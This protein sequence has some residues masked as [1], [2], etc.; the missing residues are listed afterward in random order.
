MTELLLRTRLHE[1]MIELKLTQAEKVV[2]EV[3]REAT[4]RQIS[5]TDVMTQL[6]EEELRF[7]R[8]RGSTMRIQLAHFPYK[9]TIEQFDFGFQPT[10]DQRKVEELATMS[11]IEEASNVVFLGPPGVG[12]THLSVAL[13]IRAC[14]SGYSTYF[15]SGHELGRQLLASL[16]DETTGKKLI[17]LQKYDLLIIDEMGYLPFEPRQATL[18]FQLVAKRYEK[19]SIIL[20]SNKGF[21][22]WAE[23]FGGDAAVAAAILDRLLHHCSVINV[24]GPSYRLKDRRDALGLQETPQST[25]Q[26]YRPTP[27]KGGGAG[28]AV[29]STT[30]P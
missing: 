30:T 7:R 9:K 4:E 29:T 8:D 17:A 12:K 10:I 13:G 23:V 21:G 6:L 28:A 24:R 11:F 2:D 5:Y 20:T 27:R 22:Q 25:S 18:L 14:L 1:Q 26:E 15:I 16:A 3:C 19:G